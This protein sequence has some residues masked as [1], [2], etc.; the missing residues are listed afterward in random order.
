MSGPQAYVAADPALKARLMRRATN[1]SVLVAV[2]LIAAKLAAWLATGSVAM[3]A[4][5][6]DSL[7]DAV[8]S[9]ANLLAVRHARTPAEGENRFGHGKAEALAGLGPAALQ[10]GRRRG[11]ERR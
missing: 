4:S 10:R 11:R 7:L 3:L 2:I 9:V 6:V 1:A 8:A 5:L